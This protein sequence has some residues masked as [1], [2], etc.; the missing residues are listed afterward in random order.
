MDEEDE[1]E[2]Y[3]KRRSQAHQAVRQ[4]HFGF[5]KPW[6]PNSH[7]KEGRP[8]QRDNAVRRHKSFFNPRGSDHVSRNLW[9]KYYCKRP[10]VYI[11]IRTSW[12]TLHSCI[13]LL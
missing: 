5:L 8:R 6:V 9:P 2:E 13:L 10:E 1:E 4:Q 7:P 12:A 3:Q 11:R